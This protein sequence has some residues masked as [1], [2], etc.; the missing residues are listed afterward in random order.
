MMK[1]KL[2]MRLIQKYEVKFTLATY[3]GFSVASG[4][5]KLDMEKQDTNARQT[6]P[7]PS[8]DGKSAA[9]G[10][11]TESIFLSMDSTRQPYRF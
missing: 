4:P 6:R 8:D 7:T 10:C 5:S 3:S 9:P 2:D 11:A 1:A